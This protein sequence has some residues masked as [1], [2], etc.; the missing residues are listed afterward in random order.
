MQG[1]KEGK[2]YE[3]VAGKEEVRLRTGDGGKERRKG[4]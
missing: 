1:R 2:E 4:G 3:S